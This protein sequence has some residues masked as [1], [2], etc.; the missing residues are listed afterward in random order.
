MRCVKNCRIAALI[1]SLAGI[2]RTKIIVAVAVMS[3]DAVAVGPFGNGPTDIA[4]FMNVFAKAFKPRSR[5]TRLGPTS[6]T[7]PME[8]ISRGVPGS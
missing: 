6:A 5:T 8:A 4:Y 3:R 1:L 2:E 7:T